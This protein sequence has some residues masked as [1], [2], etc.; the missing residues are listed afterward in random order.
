MHPSSV[1]SVEEPQPQEDLVQHHPLT[2][3]QRLAAARREKG[4]SL[5]DVFNGTKIKLAHIAAIE[6]DDRASLPAVPFTAGF[7]K[8]YAQFL[9]FNPDDYAGA[10]RVE[11]GQPG[12]REE[13][14]AEPAAPAPAGAREAGGRTSAAGIAALFAAG[15]AGLALIYFGAQWMARE[16]LPDA[17]AA[18]VVATET[19]KSAAPILASVVPAQSEAVADAPV[20]V[21]PAASA[22]PPAPVAA[23]TAPIPASTDVSP[24]RLSAPPRDVQRSDASRTPARAVRRERAPDVAP[25]EAM[26]VASLAAPSQE[27]PVLAAAEEFAP[28]EPTIVAAAVTRSVAAAYPER[29][30]RMAADVEHIDVVMDIT[31]EGRPTNARV[32]Q[33]SN[34]CFN[35]AAIE[36][37]MRMRFSPRTVDGEPAMEI[38]KRVTVRFDE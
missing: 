7:I 16:R 31:V 9:G 19:E 26:T 5:E 1:P 25:T 6:A 12:L 22:A 8:A 34:P 24:S 35:E 20:A 28:A 14:P 36:A 2:V 33:S 38:A 4:L 21:E 3:G 27:A 23:S 37:A 18:P 17:G 29:C 32:T 10:Y 11:V 13:L 15:A 30:A